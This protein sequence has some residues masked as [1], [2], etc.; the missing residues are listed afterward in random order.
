[1]K[2]LGIIT[3]ILLIIG[4]LNWGILALLDYNVIDAIFG[5]TGIEKIVYILIG[6]AAVWK[7]FC[8][9]KCCS[10]SS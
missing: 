6:L 7:A 8:F 4:G 2:I 1:M 9:S 10:K 5:G 3:I